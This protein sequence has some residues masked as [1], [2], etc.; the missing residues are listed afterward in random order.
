VTWWREVEELLGSD[1]ARTMAAE[2]DGAEAL[3]HG[4]ASIVPEHVRLLEQQAR[5]ALAD[6]R[7]EISP[8][9]SA[10]PEAWDQWLDYWGRRRE[11]LEALALRGLPVPQTP[12]DLA[13]LWQ[14][15]LRAINVELAIDLAHLKNLEVVGTGQPGSFRISGELD[16]MNVEAV[17]R[18]LQEEL[19]AGERLTLDFSGLTFIDSKGLAMLLQLAALALKLGLSPLVLRSPSEVL[20][21]VLEVGLPS[22]IPGIQ[23]DS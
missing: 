15:T 6:G 20:R 23:L 18:H 16:L 2:K 9:L 22:R 13:A 10:E 14:K 19:R 7:T 21:R 1:L 8:E 5:H 17:S 11:W 3:G 4:V 12:M